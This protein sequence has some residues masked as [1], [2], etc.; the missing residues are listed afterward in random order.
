MENP[1]PESGGSPARRAYTMISPYLRSHFSRVAIGAGCLFAAVA[2]RILEPWPLQYVVDH[3][4]LNHLSQSDK[5]ASLSSDNATSA[6]LL[7]AM[8]IVMVA[9]LRALFEYTRAVSFAWIGNRVVAAIRRDVFRHLQSLS[10]RFHNESRRGDLTVRLVG[11]LNMIRDVAVT[12]L[13]P[14]IASV[15]ILL[16]M[17]AVMLWMHW[18]L[19][20]MAI[21][22]FPLFWFAATGSSR[23]IHRAA[24]EQR[25]CEGA[26]AATA[27]ESLSSV[28]VVQ[29]LSLE[30]H[31]ADTF[32]AQS[33]KSMKDG[34]KTSRLSAA[35]ERK[36]DVLIAIATAMVL[37]QGSRYVLAGELSIGELVV[38]LAY[39]KRGFKP[40]QN[41]AKYTGRISKALAAT[42]RV[43]EILRESPDV[44]ES[45]DAAIAPDLKGR[46]EF[47]GVSFGYRAGENVF[48][49]LSLT[50]EPGTRVAII[51]ESGVGKSTLLSLVSRLHDPLQ[52]RV[53][54][55]GVDI[56]KWTL[57]SLRN[58]QGV[59]MQENAIFA[60]TVKGNISL[61]QSEMSDE[62]IQAA[63]RNAGAHE[64]I[65]R[66]SDGYE[67]ML[68][69]HGANLSRGQVQRIAVA[70]AAAQHSPIFLVDEPTTGLDEVN[71]QLVIEGIMKASGGRTTLIVT[72]DLSL[73]SQ[74]DMVVVLQDG[75]CVESG[76]PAELLNLGGL[77][78]DRVHGLSA[79]SASK[80]AS[81]VVAT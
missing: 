65:R 9:G 19:G 25:S 76:S 13:L 75:R 24:K 67:T 41:F 49:D 69:E 11:D 50:I 12:A 70:R 17:S 54:I 21:A 29:A 56:R 81:H 57:A 47:C 64:F 1:L 18:Q 30:N 6:L 8:I 15:V 61:L 20:L 58:Q 23:K 16:G 28:K 37:F 42:D 71:K 31:F 4:L 80:R 72:H 73:A 60:D 26:L 39:L 51:G 55:D 66:L 43:A 62:Q 5:M 27:S 35:L 45:P 10:L 3:V 2:M 59:V 46:I 74:A 44:H 36:V 68:G 63:A 14:M 48:K 22:I 53:L 38:F 77:Y 32:S 33:D 7:C 52:G 79:Q 40:L 34:V 78:A